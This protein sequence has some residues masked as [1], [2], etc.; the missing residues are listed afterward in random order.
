L[1]F[2]E[3]RKIAAALKITT[4]TRVKLP[5]SWASV[6]QNTANKDKRLQSLILDARFFQCRRSSSLRKRKREAADTH[7]EASSIAGETIE[8]V[9]DAGIESAI[10]E[11][12]DLTLN[13][14][15][16]DPHF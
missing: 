2:V 11:T 3:Q 1:R 7:D 6:Y 10:G 13:A 8:Q 12:S 9:G 14:A 4:R 5:K 16:V 15:V